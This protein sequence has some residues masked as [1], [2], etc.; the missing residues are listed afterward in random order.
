MTHSPGAPVPVPFRL[1]RAAAVVAAI[2]TLPLVAGPAAAASRATHLTV[3]ATPS[4]VIV[5]GAVLVTGVAT[6]ARAGSTVVLQRA[7][8]TKWTVIAH[9]KSGATGTFAFHLKAPQAAATWL[10]RVTRSAGG[11]DKAGVSASRRVHVVTT[12]FSVS[13]AATL[14]T[15]AGT[16]VVSGIVSPPAPGT[17]TLQRLIG[18]VW[19]DAATDSL[20]TSGGYSI[21]VSLPTA[22][23]YSLRVVKAFSATIAQGTSKPLSVTLPPPAPVIVQTA[24]PKAVIGRAF[25]TALSATAGTAPYTWSATGL[26][27][28]IALTPAGVLAGTSLVAGS[29]P[30]TVSLTDA[31]G[32]NASLVTTFVVQQTTL[33]GFGYNY[34]GQVGDG[35]TEDRH[36]PVAVQRLDAVTSV[37]G[38]AG[39]VLAVRVDGSV[40]VWGD[41]SLGQ[42]GLPSVVDTPVPTPVPGLSAV[43]ATASGQTTSYTLTTDGTVWASGM[44]D[45]GQL[46][47]GTTNLSR[48]FSP[49]QGLGPAKAIASAVGTG[50]ALL[51]D[52]TVWSWGD[53]GRDQLGDGASGGFSTHPVRVTGIVG[54]TAIATT[55][56]GGYALL[57]DGTVR[58]WGGGQG[59]ALGNGATADSTLPVAV[60]GLAGVRALANNAGTDAF[61]LKGDGTV[62][63]WG[64]NNEGTI[65]DGTTTDRDLPTQVTGATGA[66]S[67]G[68]FGAAYAVMPDGTMRSWGENSE[69]A[70][71]LGD[72]T[73]RPS[74][75]TAPGISGA[76]YTA[77]SEA[78]GFVV[79]ASG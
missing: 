23:T 32:Q 69:G 10:L 44:N 31:G 9:Q 51:R 71:G 15:S 20:N 63:A 22:A 41:N 25:T 53:N 40:W 72:T 59:G 34:S 6:P 29:Y 60:V 73:N 1:R 61:A 7:N 18:G 33:V 64:P 75:T 50:Y 8:G 55:Y 42:I 79:V 66:V 43:V 39:S 4:T 21:R 76:V 24:L 11:G 19:T 77:G 54:A 2:V 3:S 70:L 37:S 74:P 56:Q 68:V 52:G 12:A 46:G 45:K 67:I 78:T 38:N 13:A 5:G 49:V 16:V 28:G 26:P 65:G 57:A 62:W 58:A 14:T 27:A 30:V 48:V 47:D 36:S 17:V 35:T